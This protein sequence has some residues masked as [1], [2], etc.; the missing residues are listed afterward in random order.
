MQ[1]TEIEEIT[2]IEKP[3]QEKHFS[4]FLLIFVCIASIYAYYALADKDEQTYLAELIA[5]RESGEQLPKGEMHDYCHLLYVLKDSVPL[6]CVCV[7][8]GINWDKP[9]QNPEKLNGDWEDVTNPN[10]INRQRFKNKRYPKVEIYFDKAIE[11]EY[12]GKNAAIRQ[13]HWHRVNP[14]SKNDKDRYLDIDCNAIHKNNPKSH[15]FPKK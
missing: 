10:D 15:I 7:L 11:S 8:D 5:R 2:S 9:P 13:N 1:A 14:N 6:E 3:K 12:K 4:L